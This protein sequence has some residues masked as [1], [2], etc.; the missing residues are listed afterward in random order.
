MTKFGG[1]N[2]MEGVLGLDE[3]PPALKRYVKAAARLKVDLPTDLETESIPLK[4]LSSLAEDI[5]VKT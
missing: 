5:D 1:L 3:T 2:T 4:E